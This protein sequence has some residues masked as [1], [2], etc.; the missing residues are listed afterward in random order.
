M[1]TYQKQGYRSAQ[2]EARNHV[3][4]VVPILRDPV[5]ARQEGCAEGPEA[6]HWLGQSAALRLD[7]ACDVHLGEDRDWGV[8]SS[9]CTR[10]TDTCTRTHTNTHRRARTKAGAMNECSL[11]SELYSLVG[12][13]T[14][15]QR[16][17]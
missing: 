8:T 6:Q 10:C 4:A 1:L 11:I 16:H 3:R 15:L 5:E 17:E 13:G 2:D 9:L 12:M 7:C 14:E